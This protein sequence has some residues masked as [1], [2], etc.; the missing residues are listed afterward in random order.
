MGVDMPEHDDQEQI[1]TPEMLDLRTPAVLELT[2]DIADEHCKDTL[3][4]LSQSWG[5]PTDTIWYA[6]A[7]GKEAHRAEEPAEIIG[8]TTETVD[9]RAA[10]CMLLKF[11]DGHTH[12]LDAST[13][14]YNYGS[15]PPL[16]FRRKVE[17]PPDE[18]DEK[19]DEKHR[20]P[21]YRVERPEHRRHWFV[22][23]P[24]RYIRL[25]YAIIV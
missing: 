24:E 10:W 21:R 9:G 13:P 5:L 23:I 25:S 17:L 12:P 20:K 22:L 6:V 16:C 11:A 3:A 2:E 1:K 19:R 18:E 7:Y 8:G 4:D 14:C 15:K